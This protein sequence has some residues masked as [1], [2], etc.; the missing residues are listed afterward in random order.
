MTGFIDESN[1]SHANNLTQ[2]GTI[3]G[4]AIRLSR[5]KHISPTKTSDKTSSLPL[6][7][8][9]VD[10]YKNYL[11]SIKGRQSK[12]PLPVPINE[13]SK[14]LSIETY[15]LT[16]SIQAK[17]IIG[18]ITINKVKQSYKDRSAS[19]EEESSFSTSKMDCDEKIGAK[20]TKFNV[21]KFE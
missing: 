6:T 17:D 11:S 21:S 16:N 20:I 8:E 2:Y 1:T 15:S 13:L 5:M 10:F 9:M 19:T 7:P 18:H 4:S 3:M 14:T 12:Y